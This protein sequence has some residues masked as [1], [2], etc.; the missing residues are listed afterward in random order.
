MDLHGIRRCESA[1]PCFAI[2]ILAF[3]LLQGG[4]VAAFNPDSA[5]PPAAPAPA[6]AP[7]A[8]EA[9]KEQPKASGAVSGAFFAELKAIDQSSGKTA[10]VC[11]THSQSN[12]SHTLHLHLISSPLNHCFTV[13]STSL[14]H[15]T[16]HLISSP[17][18]H[19]FTVN[20]T[21]LTHTTLHLI[22]SPLNHCFT[23]NPNSLTHT[24]LHL[25]S[26]H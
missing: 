10:G 11:H 23:V 19:C 17:L 9:K 18:N 16:L 7:A 8:E 26:S 13:N 6:A 12:L 4:D 5:P 21:S 25:I 2:P 24:T 22:S 20:S 1:E 15:T 14:T 3:C